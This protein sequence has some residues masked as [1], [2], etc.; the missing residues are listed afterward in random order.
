MYYIYSFFFSCTWLPNEILQY[1]HLES[2][3]SL[4]VS[5]LTNE[6]KRISLHWG[7]PN[8]RSSGSHHPLI[9]PESL[10]S[11]IIQRCQD[12]VRNGLHKWSDSPFSFYYFSISTTSK[13]YVPFQYDCRWDQLRG[14]SGIQNNTNPVQK[15]LDC[16]CKG[17]QMFISS[18]FL[19]SSDKS[20]GR[21]HALSTNPL[22]RC[23]V[24][25]NLSFSSLTMASWP[26]NPGNFLL[27]CLLV[28]IQ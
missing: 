13:G 22:G 7:H 20:C 1:N 15:P 9:W 6:V 4:E 10:G 11:E 5:F 28:R 21:S 27:S 2:A 24:A 19:Q 8:K 25:N 12:S 26:K 3:R 16:C 17:N 18:L 14:C 23:H